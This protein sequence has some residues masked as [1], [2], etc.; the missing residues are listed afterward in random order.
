M[1]RKQL[2]QVIMLN[3]KSVINLLLL[4]VLFIASCSSQVV[5][6]NEKGCI[7]YISSLKS[8]EPFKNRFYQLVRENYG[9]VIFSTDSN[10]YTR[11]RVWFNH[12]NQ[13]SLIDSILFDQ[14]HQ[15]S[16]DQ[17][18]YFDSLSSYLAMCKEI[19][20]RYQV[21]SISG[22]QENGKYITFTFKNGRDLVYSYEKKMI[23]ISKKAN[24]RVV[25]TKY[26][27]W[28]LYITETND[29]EIIE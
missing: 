18:K 14:K 1:I 15:N 22:T 20:H 11:A 23:V 19:S 8:V 9:I 26:P 13:R 6:S 5:R 12:T 7:K 27:N 17:K 29:L 2:T 4:F 3:S 28:T 16:T 10:T 24:I 21:I 25:Q